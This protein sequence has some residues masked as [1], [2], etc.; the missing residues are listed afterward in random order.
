[1]RLHSSFLSHLYSATAFVWWQLVVIIKG[2]IVAPQDPNSFRPAFIHQRFLTFAS[3]ASR[4][5]PFRQPRRL[6]CM[7]FHSTEQRQT[8]GKKNFGE[9]SL[10]HLSPSFKWTA[11]GWRSSFPFVEKKEKYLWKQ[12]PHESEKRVYRKT[13]GIQVMGVESKNSHRRQCEGN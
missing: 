1:M 10:P 12:F 5:I 4:L 8:L 2:F 13:G 11:T 3:E 6:S 7:A 9:I